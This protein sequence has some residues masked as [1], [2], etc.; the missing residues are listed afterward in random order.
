MM[1]VAKRNTSE[2]V[3]RHLSITRTIQSKIN[4]KNTLSCTQPGRIAT[5]E[6]QAETTGYC[7][8]TPDVLKLSR[9][10]GV[11]ASGASYLRQERAKHTVRVS[12]HHCG[13]AFRGAGCASSEENNFSE[14]LAPK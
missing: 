6:G 1:A 14:S 3:G 9:L 13:Q 7:P 4:V 8:L 2:V 5:G 12:T 10:P 11:E